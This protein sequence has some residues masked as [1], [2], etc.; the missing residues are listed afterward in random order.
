MKLTTDDEVEY[1]LTIGEGIE[2]T[3]SAIA[4]GLAPAWAVGDAG[5]LGRFPVLPGIDALTILIDHDE[6]GCGQSQ[7]AKCRDRW[8]AADR[9]VLTVIPDRIGADINDLLGHRK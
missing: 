9:E 8:L 6:N 3:L 7:A 1:G 5:E 2:T 4:L